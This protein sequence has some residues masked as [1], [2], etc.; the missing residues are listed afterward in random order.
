MTTWTLQ[1][2]NKKHC[3]IK[4]R[5]AKGESDFAGLRRE[6]ATSEVGTDPGLPFKLLIGGV[7]VLCLPAECVP[8]GLVRPTTLF[9]T[10]PSWC[11]L[12]SRF[13]AFEV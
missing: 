5:S 12:C 3:V 8:M 2:R 4:R 1:M 10:G 6:A 7:C 11:G 9:R 13:E